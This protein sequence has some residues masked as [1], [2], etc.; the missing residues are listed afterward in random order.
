MHDHGGLLWSSM[1]WYGMVVVVVFVPVCVN[2][3]EAL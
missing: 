1:F 2:L 3:S